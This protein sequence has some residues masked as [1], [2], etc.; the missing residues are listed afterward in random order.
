MGL[1]K[2]VLFALRSDGNGGFLSATGFSVFGFYQQ[3]ARRPALNVFQD[4][5]D[6]YF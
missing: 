3:S 4:V 5:G 2:V 6:F 1:C